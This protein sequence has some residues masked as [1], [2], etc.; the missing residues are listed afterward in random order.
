MFVSICFLGFSRTLIFVLICLQILFI[1]F[2]VAQGNKNIKIN[3][4]IIPKIEKILSARYKYEPK[5]EKAMTNKVMSND[6]ELIKTFYEP[7]LLNDEDE[8]ERRLIASLKDYETWYIGQR[9][10][11]D[12]FEQKVLQ[13]FPHFHNVMEDLSTFLWRQKIG[14]SI[15][16]FTYVKANLKYHLTPYL[17]NFTLNSKFRDEVKQAIDLHFKDVLRKEFK[18]SDADVIFE[19]LVKDSNSFY[20]SGLL[21]DREKVKEI[22]QNYFEKLDESNHAQASRP[23]NPQTTRN[24]PR[25]TTRTTFKPSTA[26]TTSQ[27]PND[28]FKQLETSLDYWYLNHEKTSENVIKFLRSQN[29][30]LSVIRKMTQSKQ[31]FEVDFRKLQNKFLNQQMEKI[32][33]EKFQKVEEQGKV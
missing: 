12:N 16:S 28:P 24:Q 10:L 2:A 6:R 9:E 1:A 21:F 5:F 22:V 32:V 14:T 4:E 25:V 26:R 29:T 31:T 13:W 17:Q 20:Q 15:Q 8:L 30:G 18:V 3:E 23:N 19:K 7:R 27:A 11:F 33:G